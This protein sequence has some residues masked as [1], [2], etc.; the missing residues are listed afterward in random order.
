VTIY[1][2]PAVTTWGSK[3]SCQQQHDGALVGLD[4]PKSHTV[5]NLLFVSVLMPLSHTDPLVRSSEQGVLRKKQFPC[6]FV[7]L[8]HSAAIRPEALDERISFLWTT[9]IMSAFFNSEHDLLVAAS[10]NS[11]QVIQTCHLLAGSEFIAASCSAN[12]SHLWMHTRV[13]HK[14]FR[15]AGRFTPWRANF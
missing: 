15:P 9:D 5:T 4:V 13:V 10:S 6:E 7:K 3:A 11:R 8:F 12:T 1:A 14:V 2:I